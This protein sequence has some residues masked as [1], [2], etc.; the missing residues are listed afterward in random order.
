MRNFLQAAK[1]CH[2]KPINI[3]S[4]PARQYATLARQQRTCTPQPPDGKSFSEGRWFDAPRTIPSDGFFAVRR[5]Q[6]K[7]P[8]YRFSHNLPDGE[9]AARQVR[10]FL[11]SGVL[12]LLFFATSLAQAQQPSGFPADME[13]RLKQE[14]L[15]GLVHTMNVTVNDDD[16]TFK[17]T[18]RV[19]FTNNSPDTLRQIFFHA[20]FN[21]FQPNSLTHKRVAAI[22][23]NRLKPETFANL[24]PNEIGKLDILPGTSNGAPFTV[25]RLGTIIRLDLSKPLLPQ[26]R[27]TLEFEFVGQVP[28]QV[29]RS[30]R[31]NAQGVRYSM[32]QWFP[33]LCQYDQHGWQ[34]NQFVLREF[35]GVWGKYD[36]KITLPAKLVVGASGDLQ[37]P[38]ECGF[39]YVAQGDTTVMPRPDAEKPQGTKTW[40]FVAFP[41]HDFAWVADADYIHRVVKMPASSA[42]SPNMTFHILT[43]PKYDA[44]WKNAT[45]WL[46]RIFR[47]LGEKY[48]PY[49]YKQFT[50]TQAGDG[51]M[52]Y[53]NLVMV[54]SSDY[55]GTLGTVAH[56]AIH[57]WFYG[58]AAN[59]ETKHAWM[60][61]GI[62][63]YL[64]DRIMAEEFK[65]DEQIRSTWLENTLI[66]RR[67]DA[68][69]SN[70]S[71]LRVYAL[72]YDE[73]LSIPHDRFNEDMTAVMVYRKGSAWMRQFEYSFGK[74]K[75]DAL[76]RN[77]QGVWRFRHPYP[78]DFEK[79]AS[80]TFGQRMDEVFDTFLRGTELPDY[81]LQSLRSEPTADGKFKN[82]LQ[83]TKRERA[84][85]P[86]NLFASDNA[87]L[88]TK[89]HIPSDMLNAPNKD[90]TRLAPWFWAAGD[91]TAEFITNTPLR[92]VRLDTAG[93]LLRS[94][95]TKNSIQAGGLFPA[96]PDVKFGFMTRF[97]EAMPL[98]YYGVSVRPTV[99]WNPVGGFQLGLRADGI[100]T[101]NSPK[102]TFG[103]YF[104]FEQRVSPYI[105]IDF[106]FA[107]RQNWKGGN[108]L[109][110]GEAR[111]FMMDGVWGI[112]LRSF[113]D[114]RSAIRY[115]GE[116]INLTSVMMD[117][118]AFIDPTYYNEQKIL[119]R[120]GA[121]FE[122]RWKTG[123]LQL[124]PNFFQGSSD[125]YKWSGSLSLRTEWSEILYD[126]PLFS[127]KS[128]SLLYI[129]ANGLD[130]G[131]TLQSGS[132]IDNYENVPARFA[133]IFSISPQNFSRPVPSDR[134][135]GFGLPVFTPGG[136]GFVRSQVAAE[137]LIIA[138]NFF[139]GNK[140]FKAIGADIP[141]IQ[142]LKP[143][144][145][146]SSALA[147]GGFHFDSGI[148][149]SINL[150]DIAPESRLLWMFKDEVS[151]TAYVPLVSYIPGRNWVIGYDG[152]RIGVSTTIPR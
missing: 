12:L 108:I 21:A 61:E 9:E 116:E 81:T 99:W 111:L 73:P 131:T 8:L 56:E 11:F 49:P 54:R 74:D 29:R 17:G 22:G 51:G 112:S 115:A 83:L 139:L 55:N 48:L 101:Y 30:G 14:R 151:L 57:Q 33:K 120:V 67:K 16:F 122:K 143:G 1:C 82:T 76:L 43:K 32:A 41:V 110:T 78:P 79:L 113:E 85:V 123:Y 129:S 70:R 80:E 142:F 7:Y 137:P 125:S 119:F 63:D 92:E 114:I 97:D 34:N 24:K 130:N 146:V 62:T 94:D 126:S 6:S 18:S 128:R 69:E 124:E 10:L 52:E 19:E 91:Y 28:V 25:E 50:C 27:T 86:L 68:L 20:H 109:N 13:E 107:I 140:T 45:D 132:I 72:G 77:Y 75:I 149:L 2:T 36:V 118:L 46:P 104:N 58:M 134:F 44:V 147:V 88:R 64:T 100:G 42:I 136:G 95:L 38:Q 103:L 141:V 26:E 89:I 59:N 105:P 37:N 96:M 15:A 35:Y 145:W 65:I 93:N 133:R 53:P 71:F 84:H 102:I 135:V 90:T 47:F 5:V 31:N 40:H 87:G 152:V 148:S 106:Q 150:A 3:T 4:A 144:A 23:P 121:Q 98:D 66:P 138:V 117:G 39:G 60:D 127:I